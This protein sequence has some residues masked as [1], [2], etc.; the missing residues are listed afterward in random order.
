MTFPQSPWN[1][2]AVCR[3]GEVERLTATLK[4]AGIQ[5]EVKHEPNEPKPFCVWVHDDSLQAASDAVWPKPN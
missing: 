3:E 2:F 1:L 5:F 4:S